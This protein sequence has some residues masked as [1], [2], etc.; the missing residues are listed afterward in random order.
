VEKAILHSELVLQD[1]AEHGRQSTPNRYV[2]PHPRILLSV[3]V[4]LQFEIA[5]YDFVDE[6]GCIPELWQLKRWN[7]TWRMGLANCESS[8]CGG[9][10]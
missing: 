6:L 5:A 2:P 3:P 1:S 7:I 8:E 4:C 9:A 10:E